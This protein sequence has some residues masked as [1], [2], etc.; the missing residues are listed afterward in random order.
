M[1]YPF[2]FLD[3]RWLYNDLQ[4]LQRPGPEL[5]AVWGCDNV[6]LYT[7][8]FG[9]GSGPAAWCTRRLPD[10]DLFRGR[11][12]Y[13]FPLYDRRAGRGPLNLRPELLRGL[14]LAYAGPIS[15]EAVFDAILALLSATS[16]TLRFAEDLEDVFPHVPF[17]AD[18]KVFD[19]A[20]AI[21][22]EIR[23]VETFSR[24]P[25]PDFLPS[26]L[27]RLETLPAGPLQASAWSDGEI[28]LCSDGSGRMSGIPLAVWEFSVSGYR[29]L[30][31]WLKAREGL[32][33]DKAMLDEIR[34][35]H[36]RINELIHRFDEADL[37]LAEAVTHSLTRS[38]LGL[39]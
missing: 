33:L 39:A 34:D 22:A 5:Q 32:P 9:I 38:Q 2:R 1:F 28:R 23:A 17:P 4:Y 27:A 14:A 21:G 35:I 26:H 16:Y 6:S 31:R 11:G 24:A 30:P 25:G 8:T 37:V 20:A 10:Y 12:G 18:R 13:A 7:H 36:G 29:V 19:R 3:H 15:P